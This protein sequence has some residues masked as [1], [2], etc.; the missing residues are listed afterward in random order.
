MACC[1]F[2]DIDVDMAWGLVSLMCDSMALCWG[3]GLVW[4]EMFNDHN[5]G[6]TKS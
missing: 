6:E 5:I 4:L 3:S 1:T 2:P